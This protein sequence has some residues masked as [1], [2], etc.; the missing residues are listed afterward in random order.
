MMGITNVRKNDIFRMNP[1]SSIKIMNTF[2]VFNFLSLLFVPAL[3]SAQDVWL[4]NSAVSTT[5]GHY[6]NAL[7]L[8]K[9]SGIGMRLTAEKN[10]TWGITAGLQTTRIGMQPIV[11]TA[12]QNQ[13]DWLF[14]GWINVPTITI[15]G[16]WKF[17][18][19]TYKS[20]NDANDTNSSEVRTVAPKI[21]WIAFGI[22]LKVDLSH[23][24][25]KYKYTEAIKQISLGLSY[26]FNDAKDWFQVR[27]YTINR[28]M[29][30]AAMGHTSVQATDIKLTHLISPT[31]SWTPISVTL[32][33][34]RGQKIYSLDVD[35]QYIYNLP[36]LNQGGESLAASWRIS[37]Q[38]LLNAQLKKNKY[39]SDQPVNNNFNLK[40]LGL[41]LVTTW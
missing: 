30:A 35:S 39:S 37:P 9:Q 16:L 15:P 14:S 13:D 24:N 8:K 1:N 3:A 23:S 11:P 29:P 26:G 25:S 7:I 31:S 4:V 2:K 21:T 33:I 40:S 22:P 28:L 34:E 17:Q 41:Q 19:D 36:M 6:E 32:G 38:V 20:T 12:V 18:L 27:T 10:Q 5:T